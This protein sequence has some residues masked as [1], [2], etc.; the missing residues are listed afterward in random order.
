MTKKNEIASKVNNSI[1]ARTSDY[2]SV[3]PNFLSK[4]FNLLPQNH[5]NWA[6]GSNVKSS[7]ENESEFTNR[8]ECKDS[9][10]CILIAR[11]ANGSTININNSSDRILNIIE[12]NVQQTN[13]MLE[14][15]CE[16]LELFMK[17]GTL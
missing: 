8:Q 3:N 5:S 1:L 9:T 7:D 11:D 13:K 14:I 2:E 6:T 15:V 10:N 17:G 16:Y 12:K 4:G